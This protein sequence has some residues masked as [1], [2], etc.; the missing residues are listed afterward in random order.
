MSKL[1]SRK[2][3]ILVW[4]VVVLGLFAA[5]EAP[6]S[7]ASGVLLLVVWGMVPA[8]IFMLWQRPSRTMAEVLHQAETRSE[9][10]R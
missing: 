8:I 7:F 1:L 4:L 9:G 6:M 10:E 2:G 3:M 5:L